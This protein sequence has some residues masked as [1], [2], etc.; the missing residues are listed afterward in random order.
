MSTILIPV[1]AFGLPLLLVLASL[2]ITVAPWVLFN[3][4][5]NIGYG[6]PLPTNTTW[7][8]L[9]GSIVPAYVPIKSCDA[10]WIKASLLQTF[11]RLGCPIDMQ[12]MIVSPTSTQ[13]QP[14]HDVHIAF[15]WMS[16]MGLILFGSWGARWAVLTR[17][18]ILNKTGYSSNRYCRLC[19][20]GM[21]ISIWPTILIC[22]WWMECMFWLT[23][24]M[25]TQKWCTPPTSLLTFD[26]TAEMDAMLLSVQQ[27]CTGWKI[28]YFSSSIPITTETEIQWQWQPTAALDMQTFG[29]LYPVL[30][31]SCISSIALVCLHMCCTARW[32]FALDFL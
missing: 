13:C 22:L 29:Y 32:S 12:Q 15:L 18:Y 26:R 10:T 16:G 28:D 25:T 8:T 3:E 9:D 31:G 24:I 5:I 20:Y 14:S 27:H 11:A 21:V 1:M 6:A 19:G 4:G 2:C 7:A 17:R 30:V 23:A